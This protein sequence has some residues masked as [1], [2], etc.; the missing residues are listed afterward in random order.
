VLRAFVDDSHVGDKASPCYVLAGWVAPNSAWPRFSQD[1][2][3]VLRMSPRIRHFKFD[4]AMGLSGEF[5]G[6]TAQSRDE[7]LRLLV[8]LLGEYAPLGIASI[9]PRELFE[10]ICRSHPH[11]FIRNPYALLFFGVAG[12]LVKHYEWAGS[13]EKIEFVF[14][15][16]PGGKMVQLEEG[17]Q[18]FVDAAPPDAR[19]LL[20]DHAPSFLDDRQATSLQAADL[21]AGLVHLFESASLRGEAVPAFAW[22]QGAANLTRVY[23]MMDEKWAR[24]AIAAMAGPAITYRY[25]YGYTPTR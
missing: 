25:G 22:G 7:K 23:W 10:R 19:A 9:L 14:D 8:N 3:A 6:V 18:A 16:Q 5:Q 4:E 21:H 20:C 1:W 17:W 24:G 2:D 12:R 13:T 15:Y 11:R